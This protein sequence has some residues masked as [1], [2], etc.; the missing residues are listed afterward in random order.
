[1]EQENKIW[2]LIERNA[3]PDPKE[4]PAEAM[5]S[6]RNACLLKL[7]SL[8][9]LLLSPPA[10][11]EELLGILTLHSRHTLPGGL[12]LQCHCRAFL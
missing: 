1:M 12:R 3:S 5:L 4:V 9:F 2:D 8:S 6:H 11:E 7:R 10:H